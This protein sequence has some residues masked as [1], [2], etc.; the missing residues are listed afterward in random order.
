MS[1]EVLP[2][3]DRLAGRVLKNMGVNRPEDTMIKQLGEAIKQAETDIKQE[4]MQ[5]QAPIPF[6]PG[7]MGA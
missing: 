6:D 4:D 5:K 7:P 1:E 3:Y 2:Y